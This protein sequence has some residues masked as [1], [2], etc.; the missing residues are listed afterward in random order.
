MQAQGQPL[1]QWLNVNMTYFTIAAALKMP[2]V[3]GF[4]ESVCYL[5]LFKWTEI[6]EINLDL[7]EK[8]FFCYIFTNNLLK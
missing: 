1:S 2:L 5:E 4:S 8:I 7:P 3:F 6:S